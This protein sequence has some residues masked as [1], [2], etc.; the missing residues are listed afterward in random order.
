MLSKDKNTNKN[1]QEFLKTR[2][3]TLYKLLHAVEEK[4]LRVSKKN[5]TTHFKN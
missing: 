1:L 3:E 2:S 4:L 5:K